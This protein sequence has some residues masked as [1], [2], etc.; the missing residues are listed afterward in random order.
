MKEQFRA[1]FTA[2]IEP[3]DAIAQ[4][5]RW[6]TR[7]LRSRLAPFVKAATT[8]RER[9]GIIINAI[10]Q[11]ISNGRV[12]GLNTKVRLIIRRGYGY[13]SANAALALVMLACGPINLALP[14]EQ[15]TPH[16]TK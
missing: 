8:M 7:A 16:L 9:R 11:G 1:I 13:H 5:D 3:A 4:L 15:P 12:E 2:D 10:E 14:H 6:T